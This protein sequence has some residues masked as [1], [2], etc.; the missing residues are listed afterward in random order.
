MSSDS[1]KILNLINRKYNQYSNQ[2]I[3]IDIEINNS[4][5]ENNKEIFIKIYKCMEIID[6]SY[7][8]SKIKIEKPSLDPNILKVIKDKEF[9]QFILK[10]PP[11]HSIDPDKAKLYVDSQFC[12][13]FKK[14]AE[15]LIKNTIHISHKDILQQLKDLAK[16]V[17]KIYKQ[18][19]VLIGPWSDKSN[20]FFGIF[21]MSIMYH[22]YNLLP[23]EI[24]K[25]FIDS[26][27]KYGTLVK[28]LDID[29]MMY[30][31]TQTTSMLKNKIYHTSEIGFRRL[32]DE[33]K[34]KKA[35]FPKIA[36]LVLNEFTND[37]YKD[38]WVKMKIMEKSS[39]YDGDYLQQTI[40][41][42]LGHYY[43]LKLGLEYYLIRL[44]MSTIS[45]FE[46]KKSFLTMVPVIVINYIKIPHLFSLLNNNKYI[47]HIGDFYE[48][49]NFMALVYY[50]IISNFLNVSLEYPATSCYSDYKVADEPSTFLAIYLL[51]PVPSYKDYNFIGIS[52]DTIYFALGVIFDAGLC[53]KLSDTENKK[54]CKDIE[55]YIVNIVENTSDY[56][57]NKETVKCRPFIKNCNLPCTDLYTPTNAYTASRLERCPNPIYKK[58]YLLN[59]LGH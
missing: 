48:K 38:K 47:G 8:V 25:D 58:K 7:V 52:S 9:Y 18:S 20:Y 39:K 28:Y 37:R 11:D 26:Y 23:F 33:K 4:T 34:I 27:N 10:G 57:K 13:L 41:K 51:G 42:F 2:A 22:Q 14:S 49:K 29:D 40:V 53:M 6:K 45:S 55:K 32:S 5:E 50:T 24:S 30:S 43:L 21:F 35:L 54:L 59:I 12:D 15:Q 56:E 44:F 3:D 19:V 36:S 16:K 1:K 46:I 17:I 31:G